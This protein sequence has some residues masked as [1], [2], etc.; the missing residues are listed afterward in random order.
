MGFS[1]LTARSGCPS[2]IHILQPCSFHLAGNCSLPPLSSSQSPLATAGL[3]YIAGES[4]SLIRCLMRCKSLMRCSI[5]GGEESVC[6][7]S[8]G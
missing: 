1:T 5:A 6:C 3:G 8:E 7:Q 2:I 4:Q